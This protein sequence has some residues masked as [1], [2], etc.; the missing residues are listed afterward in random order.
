MTNL[1]PVFVNERALA[2]P[3]GATVRAAVRAFDESLESRVAAGSAYVTDGR[4][5]RVE[6]DTPL[7]A[8]SILRI[9][10]SG[11]RLPE[12]ADAEP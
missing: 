4:G 2:V 7:A 9:V 8:G 11:R 1:L 12:E 3:A 10:V 5:I 6:P